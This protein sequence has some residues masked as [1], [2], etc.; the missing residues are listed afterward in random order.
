M[1]RYLDTPS[2][3][4]RLVRQFLNPPRTVRVQ[5]IAEIA[6]HRGAS[7]IYHGVT[8][9][10]GAEARGEVRLY[11]DRLAAVLFA[12]EVESITECAANQS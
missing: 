3:P 6:R 12:S 9:I 8:L 1:S 11:T 5:W 4:Q 2:G 10:L 7:A